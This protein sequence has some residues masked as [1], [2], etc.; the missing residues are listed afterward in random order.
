M[1]WVRIF[2]SNKKFVIYGAG[3]V[4]ASIY[5]AIKELY[6]CMPE[7]FLVSSLEGN[8]AEI[9]GIAVQTVLQEGSFRQDVFY[10]VAL[11]QTYH[12]A[13]VKMLSEY[14]ILREQIV[15]I[16]NE[17]ENT[18]MEA[19]YRAAADF[20]TAS[21]VLNAQKSLLSSDAVGERGCMEEKGRTEV[22]QAKCHVDKPLKNGGKSEPYLIPIQ[23]G[24]ALTDCITA[25]CRD[26]EGDNISAKNPNYC[27]LTAAY[28]AWKN[29]K[30]AYKGLCH[31]RRIFNLTQTEMER[32]FADGADVILPYPTIYYPSIEAEHSR[33]VTDA[34]W[35]AMCRAMQEQQPEYYDYYRENFSKDCYFYNFNML[36]ARK[37]VFDDYC[38][39]LFPVLERTEELIHRERKDRYA[40]YLGE[41]L[42]TLY[43]RKNS[44]KFKIVHAGKNLLT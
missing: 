37:E 25:Q 42:T 28:Y 21:E 23:V 20:R 43:F 10:I 6:H 30:A 8:P 38:Q 16:D 4:A 34:D 17:L 41:N 26:D 14:Q 9:D 36:I 2:G 44:D 13:V 39:F 15:L 19:Y 3:I 24:A 22:Y 32:I 31:Y 11:P 12:D 7:K 40:G 5:T 35:Q 33:Y 27:E 29:S 1:E 18:I